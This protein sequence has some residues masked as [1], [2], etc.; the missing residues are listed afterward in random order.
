MNDC[1]VGIEFDSS[2][3]SGLWL[4][5]NQKVIVGCDSGSLYHLSINIMDVKDKNYFSTNAILTEHDDSIL[6]LDFI[7]NKNKIISGGM[8]MK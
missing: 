1:V 8:D 4:N 7:K 6:S 2:V 5:N 3:A